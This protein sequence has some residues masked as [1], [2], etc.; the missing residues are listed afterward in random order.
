MAILSHPMPLNPRQ[1]F[2]VEQYLID[3]NGKEA[4][5]R[6]GYAPEAAGVRAAKLLRRAKIR[7]AVAA[8]MAARAARTGITAERVIA[9]YGRIAFSDWRRFAEWGPDHV[10][11]IATRALTPDERAAVAEIVETKG[12]VR[13]VKLFDKQAALNSLLR[14]LAHDERARFGA[15]APLD[16]EPPATKRAAAPRPLSDRQ[17]RFAD[18]FLEDFAASAAA[19]RAGYAP[20][21]APFLAT[22]LR[23]YPAIAARIAAGIA[24]KRLPIRAEAD[25]VIVEYARI[26]FADIGRIAAWSDKRLRIK[27]QRRIA[28]ADGAAIAALGPARGATL[29]LRLYDKVYAL[30]M[31]ARHLGL[32]DARMP[33]RAPGQTWRVQRTSAALRARLGRG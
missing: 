27:A 11:C 32:L 9:E 18:E 12:G 26:A 22:R 6:A 1:S 31:L 16:L 17:R 7:A 15:A 25:R 21:S 30:D 19:R 3:L 13:R 4:A 8:A 20:R 24:A 23:R 14:I 10:R 2:F 5:I 28:I 33:G 29:Q